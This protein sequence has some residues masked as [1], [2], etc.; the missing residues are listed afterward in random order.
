MQRGPA[1]HRSVPSDLSSGVKKYLEFHALEA[2]DVGPL[3]LRALPERIYYA[4]K[5]KQTLY[6]SAKW[7]NGTHSYY[8]DHEAHVKVYV[9]QRTAGT[10]AR[11]IPWRIAKVT[12]FVKLG[13]AIGLVYTDAATDEDMELGGP[14]IELYCIPSGKALLLIQ[15]KRTLVA[16]IWGGKLA[17]EARGI[18]Y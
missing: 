9:P 10:T 13:R 14:G 11:V 7:G 17:V 2:K 6:A 3:Q 18:V 8:H 12:T 15:E 1:E 16:M 4:G 5:M